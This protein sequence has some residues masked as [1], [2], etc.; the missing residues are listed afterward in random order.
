[1]KRWLNFAALIG[2]SI[3]VALVVE[4]I[5]WGRV[6]WPELMGLG[7][8]IASLGRSYAVFIAIFLVVLWGGY[9]LWRTIRR[10]PPEDGIAEPQNSFVN[11]WM[12][13]VGVGVLSVTLAIAAWN[14]TKMGTPGWWVAGT[15]VNLTQ[16]HDFAFDMWLFGVI[17]IVLDAGICFAILWGGY[18]LWIGFWQG[19][20]R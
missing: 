2:V 12:Y 19:R 20:N 17:P 6:S 8:D 3:I 13:V 11:R 10:K 9:L 16:K 15:V 4:R 5:F 14:L 18:L 1:M 7:T